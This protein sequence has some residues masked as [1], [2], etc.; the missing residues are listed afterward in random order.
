M[1]LLAEDTLTATTE[2]EGSACADAKRNA[3]IRP[4][5]PAMKLMIVGW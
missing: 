5:A 4:T 3:Y 1:S 2:A